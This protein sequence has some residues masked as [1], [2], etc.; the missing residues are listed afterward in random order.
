MSH[1]L[2]HADIEMTMRYLPPAE[3]EVAQQGIN[4]AFGETLAASATA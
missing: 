1:W 2:R 3:E 4:K